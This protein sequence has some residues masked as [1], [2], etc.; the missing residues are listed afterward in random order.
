M[1]STPSR[2]RAASRGFAFGVLLN[3]AFV[4]AEFVAGTLADSVA[5]IADAA[6]NLG[7]VAGLLLAWGAALLALRAPTERRTYGWRKSTIVA[8]LANALLLFGATGALTWEAIGR[9]AD[10]PEPEGMTMIVVAAIGVVVNGVSAWIL[11]RSGRGH[12]HHGH[13]HGH[14]HDHDH[15]HH[16]DINLRA[17]VQHM[18]AD[19]AVSLGVV[20]AGIVLISTGWRFIDPLTTLIIA[21]VIVVTTWSLLRESLAL[22][23]DA[24]PAHIQVDAVR[25]FLCERPGVVGVHD[26]HVWALGSSE[27]AL[28]VH[29][30]VE[31]TSAEFLVETEKALHDRFGID[32]STMQVE[33]L[34]QSS[35]RHA[36]VCQA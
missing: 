5:L 28:T 6:H 12:G 4:I 34:E 2:A 35:C 31:Q 32:H 33:S 7:D 16:D 1:P 23:L 17:A 18:V 26:L 20:A 24:V 15:G 9:L 19:A 29:M 14:G 25:R 36:K 8:A 27:V 13:D 10:P 30:V 22:T 11:L 3:T 21:V